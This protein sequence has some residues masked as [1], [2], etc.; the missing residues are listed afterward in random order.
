MFLRSLLFLLFLAT[1]A[2]RPSLAL[3][4]DPTSS[5]ADVPPEKEGGFAKPYDYER[6]AYGYDPQGVEYKENQAEDFQVI[7]I[8]SAPFTAIASFGLTGLASLAIRHTFSVDGDYLIPFIAGTVAGST[9]IA[10]LSVLTNK[11]PPP[12]SGTL[13]EGPHSREFSGFQLPLVMAKF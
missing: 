10:C 5:Q 8:T 11:Y 3:A 12:A 13:G 4:L 6:K 9:T 1:L 7:F 2:F